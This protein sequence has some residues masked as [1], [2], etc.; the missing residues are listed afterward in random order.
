MNKKQPSVTKYLERS[1]TRRAAL[2]AG[3]LAALG[4]AFSRPLIE[5]IRPSDHVDIDVNLCSHAGRID[6]GHISIVS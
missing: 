3:G 2:K 5:T 1:V 4:L 6:D